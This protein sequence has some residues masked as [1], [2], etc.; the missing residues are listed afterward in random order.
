MTRRAGAFDPAR[1][2]DADYR[3]AAS[4]LRDTFADRVGEVELPAGFADQ[5][6][7]RA[8]RLVARKRVAVAT[9]AVAAV[10][11]IASV[12][13]VV[14]APG[15]SSRVAVSSL[16]PSWPARGALAHDASTIDAATQAWDAATHGRHTVRSVLYAGTYGAGSAVLL[17]ATDDQGHLRLGGLTKAGADQPD[18]VVEDRPVAAPLQAATLV[19][20]QPSGLSVVLVVADPAFTEVSWPDAEWSASDA[21]GSSP[22]PRT[23]SLFDGLDVITVGQDEVPPVLTVSAPDGRQAQAS[24]GR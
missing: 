9:A 3:A 15:H 14:A 5:A 23:D 12:S 2:G 17:L 8:G 11:A 24:T 6:R 10:A 16:L 4:L 21:A 20:D 19:V 7:A 22:E 13:A 1:L 18:V